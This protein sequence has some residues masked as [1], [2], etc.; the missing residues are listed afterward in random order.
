MVFDP[1]VLDPDH[2]I[3]NGEQFAHGRDEG[4]LFRFGR[5]RTGADRICGS[6]G[7]YGRPPDLVAPGFPDQAETV[8]VAR[9]RPRSGPGPVHQTCLS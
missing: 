1:G 7:C 4:D 5:L 8:R 9:S 6:Q 3:D 2:G